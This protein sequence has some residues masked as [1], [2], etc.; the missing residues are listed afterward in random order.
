MAAFQEIRLYFLR[1]AIDKPQPA[2]RPPLC[3]KE[4]RLVENPDSARA[5]AEAMFKKEIRRRDGEQAMAEHLANEQAI[6][7][8]TARLRELRL[9]RDAAAKEAAP[10]KRAD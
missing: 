4:V 5:R 6:R 9:A 2:A 1:F 8:K 10:R 7:E 3:A